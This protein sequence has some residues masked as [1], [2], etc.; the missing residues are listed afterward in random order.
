M[1]GR[2]SGRYGVR[3]ICG[4]VGLVVALAACGKGGSDV[5]ASTGD[6]LVV[7]VQAPPAEATTPL[8]AL[9]IAEPVTTVAAAAPA[10]TAPSAVA[11]APAP[12]VDGLAVLQH[13]LDGLAGGYHFTTTVSVDGV[14]SAV[15]DGDRLVDGTRLTLTVG[16]GTVNYV[17]TDA[18]SWVLPEGGEWQA[19]SVAPASTDPLGALHTPASIAVN[20]ADGITTSLTATVPAVA[21]GVPG[22]ATTMAAVQVLLD[23]TGLK[24]VTYS[25]TVNGRPAVVGSSIGPIVDPTPVTPPI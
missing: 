18:G 11:A 6:R 9:A 10:P 24:T 3:Q 8:P 14:P 5:E 7:G 12:A 17:V 16:G 2:E 19:V 22:D 4:A 1:L 25:T 23:A 21:L 13:A 20:G 15:A